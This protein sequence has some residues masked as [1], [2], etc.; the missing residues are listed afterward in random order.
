MFK[1]HDTQNMLCLWVFGSTMYAGR[2]HW[3]TLGDSRGD[4]LSHWVAYRWHAQRQSW[5]RLRSS[6]HRDM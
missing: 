4:I 3:R 1:D 6:R 2:M 5:H